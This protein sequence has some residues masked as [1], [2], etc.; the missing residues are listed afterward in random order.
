MRKPSQAES[1]SVFGEGISRLSLAWYLRTEDL[2]NGGER[3]NSDLEEQTGG[4][5]ILIMEPRLHHQDGAVAELP[6]LIV[7]AHCF[8][9][10]TASFLHMQ[11]RME[12]IRDKQHISFMI[13]KAYNLNMCFSSWAQ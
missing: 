13:A 8:G 7:R 11:L 6:H 12:F 1:G 5:L 4:G 10:I 9:C 2:H 3:H